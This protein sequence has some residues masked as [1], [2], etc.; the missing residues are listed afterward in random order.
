MVL[1][2]QVI[3]QLQL[4]AAL[5]NDCVEMAQSVLIVL[6]YIRQNTLIVRFRLG[7]TLYLLDSQFKSYFVV[8][9]D[10]NLARFLYYPT[11]ILNSRH[12]RMEENLIDR[13]YSSTDQAQYF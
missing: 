3:L 9:S 6:Y 1:P 10:R 7:W 8:R 2:W 13:S 11:L 4:K 5:L 12:F